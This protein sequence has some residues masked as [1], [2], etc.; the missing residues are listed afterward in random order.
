MESPAISENEDV[1]DIRDLGSPKINGASSKGKQYL[2]SGRCHSPPTPPDSMVTAEELGVGEY[3]RNQKTGC[4]P[5]IAEMHIKRIT[6]I[7]PDS[8]IFPYIEEHEIP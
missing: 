7:I 4:W 3:V 5:Q 8:C 1:T 2:R 6:S